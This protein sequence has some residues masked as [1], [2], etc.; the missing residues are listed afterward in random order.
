MLGNADAK[1]GRV[2][3]GVF[4]GASRKG[5]AY[6]HLEQH[7][8]C[9]SV[10]VRGMAVF[11]AVRYTQVWRVSLVR[12]GF[13][14]LIISVMS[15]PSDPFMAVLEREVIIL[16]IVTLA[17][18]ALS[19]ALPIVVSPPLSALSLLLASSLYLIL[20][21]PHSTTSTLLLSVGFSSM[22]AAARTETKHRSCDYATLSCEKVA[23]QRS[24]L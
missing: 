15:P 23:E 9:D 2:D 21:S 13:L 14:I 12:L 6:V 8:A 4:P 10:C 18:A 5:S 20:C 24:C 22:L 16:L 17:W 7:Q 1:V 3:N 11:G 19:L